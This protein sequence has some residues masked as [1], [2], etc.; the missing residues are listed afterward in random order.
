MGK[1]GSL[2]L[3]TAKWD[4]G[5]RRTSSLIRIWFHTAN[6]QAGEKIILAFSKICEFLFHSFFV[7]SIP[8]FPMNIRKMGIPFT[9]LCLTP[10]EG[11]RGS[12]WTGQSVSPEEDTLPQGS[13]SSQSTGI[14]AQ[15]K[16]DFS[17]IVSKLCL[18]SQTL[19]LF[20]SWLPLPCFIDTVFPIAH[21][22][23]KLLF[24]GVFVCMCV[25]V[26]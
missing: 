21:V 18:I 24:V 23:N 16:S 25:L 5:C 14:M 2:E 17:A 7:L 3:Q 6:G 19:L 22:Q 11:G 26:F 8:F 4:A 10:G 15:S 13:K 1:F 20:R 9:L 12:W